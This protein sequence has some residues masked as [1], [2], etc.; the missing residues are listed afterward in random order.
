MPS[1]SATSA[2]GEPKFSPCQHLQV[3]TLQPVGDTEEL[4]LTT[5]A[6]TNFLAQATW[7][8]TDNVLC[9]YAER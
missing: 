3:R 7:P 2:P 6:L 9:W 8:S 4:S 5:K 1:A